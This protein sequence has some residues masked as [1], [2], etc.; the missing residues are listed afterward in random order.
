MGQR[1]SWGRGGAGWERAG[2]EAGGSSRKAGG[3]RVVLWTVLCHETRFIW[4]S[5]QH[6]SAVL[7][8]SPI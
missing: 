3:E 1:H 8:D 6:G 4:L 5:N 2:L 7:L